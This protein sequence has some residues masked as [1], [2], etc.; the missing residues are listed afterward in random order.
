M[1]AAG[2]RRHRSSK[3]LAPFSTLSSEAAGAED[4][5]CSNAGLS[6]TRARKDDGHWSLPSNQKAMCTSHWS[7]CRSAYG[8]SSSSSTVRMREPGAVDGASRR[9]STNASW[10]SR[11][12]LKQ[13]CT[14]SRRHPARMKNDTATSNLPT[15]TALKALSSATRCHFG[16][17]KSLDRRSNTLAILGFSFSN[18]NNICFLPRAKYMSMLA[19]ALLSLLRNWSFASLSS[20]ARRAPSFWSPC[21]Q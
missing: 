17:L 8:I 7:L 9:H 1:T 5:V 12:C 4:A 14:A 15:D 20:R 11:S 10:K 6:G 16:S 3:S 19:W 2:T 21:S 18:P 13:T